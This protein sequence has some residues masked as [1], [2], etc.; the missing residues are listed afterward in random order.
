MSAGVALSEPELIAGSVLMSGRVP[1]ELRPLIAPAERLAGKPFLVV[2]GIADTVLPIQNGR[3]S[4]ALLSELP[5]ELAYKE[6]PIGHEVS[7]QSLADV[8]AWLTKHLDR[9]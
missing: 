8:T 5:V 3:A 6:Y 7:T 4:R 9:L 1:A 2:H